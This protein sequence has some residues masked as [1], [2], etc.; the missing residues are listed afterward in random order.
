MVTHNEGLART[1]ALEFAVDFVSEHGNSFQKPE[2]NLGFDWY[3]EVEIADMFFE[4][5]YQDSYDFLTCKKALELSL[6][7]YKTAAFNTIN[8]ITDTADHYYGFL[9]GRRATEDKEL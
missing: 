6:R 7:H 5:L 1:S 9:F 4:F 8:H 2:T 3:D